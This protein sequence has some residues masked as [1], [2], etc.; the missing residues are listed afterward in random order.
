MR[1][2]GAGVSGIS[3]TGS[4]V[5]DLFAAPGEH[6]QRRRLAETIDRIE[7]RFG[8]GKVIPAK[9]LGRRRRAA[10]PPRERGEKASD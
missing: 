4:E 7:D 5:L 10:P 3:P 8:R 1:L 2:I 9:V 6:D